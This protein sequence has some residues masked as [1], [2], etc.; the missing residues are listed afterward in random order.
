MLINFADGVSEPKHQEELSNLLE[1]ITLEELEAVERYCYELLSK[2]GRKNGRRYEISYVPPVALQLILNNQDGPLQYGVHAGNII[3]I[4]KM[5][6]FDKKKGKFGEMCILAHE[7]GHAIMG[8]KNV[9]MDDKFGTR[10]MEKATDEAIKMY[11][12]DKFPLFYRMYVLCRDTHHHKT[13]EGD[14]KEFFKDII[15]IMEQRWAYY[16]DRRKNRLNI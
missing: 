4:I 8:V 14:F 11:I 6:S 1:Q 16:K 3:K 10:I 5:S 7:T 12:M 15:G 9:T 2:I 13:K